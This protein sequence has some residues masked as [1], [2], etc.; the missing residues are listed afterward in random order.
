MPMCWGIL[1]WVF[2]YQIPRK[3][4]HIMW[5]IDLWIF[6]HLHWNLM[7]F[8]SECLL[9][10]WFPIWLV[11]INL[12]VLASVMVARTE[13]VQL[14]FL[15]KFSRHTYFT[16]KFKVSSN[17]FYRVTQ[18]PCAD[19]LS[20][21]KWRYLSVTHCLSI[22]TYRNW[23]DSCP[24]YLGAFTCSFSQYNAQACLVLVLQY[25]CTILFLIS[26]VFAWNTILFWIII[27]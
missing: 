21:V 20:I 12:Y 11:G 4:A 14:H 13:H 22:K 25:V 5:C 19:D 26:P 9:A 23:P 27:C 16:W 1:E 15:Q 17:L 7:Q 18:S 3:A 10:A 24:P 8:A 6:Q 2:D